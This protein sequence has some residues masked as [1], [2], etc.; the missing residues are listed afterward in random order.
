MKRF[1]LGFVIAIAATCSLQ[2]DPPRFLAPLP[3]KVQEKTV[4]ELLPIPPEATEEQKPLFEAAI[5]EARKQDVSVTPQAALL[6]RGLGHLQ[7]EEYEDAAPYLEETLRLDPSQQA[8][9]EGLGWAYIKTDQQTRAKALWE[10]FQRLMPDQALPYALLGQIAVMEREWPLADKHFSKS[11]SI[12]PDQFD[13]RYWYGQNLMRLGK[14]EEAEDIFREL[15]KREPDR[16]DIQM[17]LASLLI[18]RLEYM[19][20]V[21]IYRN[22]NDELPDNPRFLVEQALLELRVGELRRADELCLEALELDEA[23]LDA[24]SL[25]ADIAEIAGLHDITPLQDLIGETKNPISR[26]ALR[27]RLA[28][29]CIVENRNEPRQ[30]DPDMIL[31]LMHKAIEE[32]PANVDYRILYAQYLVMQ[33]HYTKAHGVATTVLEKFNG[34]NIAAKK[35]LLELAL[36]ELRHE[37]A[38][39]I[40]ADIYSGL[41]AHDPMGHYY[42]A[43]IFTQLGRYADA[44]QEIDLMEA[45]ASKGA[46]LSLVYTALTESDWTPA[47]SVRRL[48][49]HIMALQREGWVLI[50]PTN[51]PAILK[52]ET[53]DRRPTSVEDGDVPATARMV[54]YLM[55]CFTGKRKFGKKEPV[56]DDVP[57]PKKYFTIVF[58]GDLRSSLLLGN[59]VAEDFGVPFGIFVPTAPSKDYVPSRAGWDELRKYA[60]TGNWIIGSHL[61]ASFEKKP[62][63]K[64]GKDMRAPLPNRIWNT[65]R[66]RVESMSEW[67]RRI[68]QEFRDSRYTIRHEMGLNDSAVGLVSYPFSDLGQEGAC[69]LHSIRD[70]MAT[71]VAEAARSY[72]VGFVQTPSGYTVFGDNLLLCRTY[73]PN[74]TDEGSDLVR[75]AYNNH[76]L[77]IA[78]KMRAEIAMLM[79]R[80]NEANI[81]LTSLR[82]DGYPEDLCREIERAI[83][84]HFQNKSRRDRPPLVTEESYMDDSTNVIIA[85]E[86]HEGREEPLIRLDHPFIGPLVFHS[87]ANDQIETFGLGLRAGLDITRNTTLSFEY[88]DSKMEQTVRP[89]WNAVIVTNVPYAKSKYKFKMQTKALKGTITHRL[90]NGTVLSASIGKTSKKRLPSNSSLTDINLQDDLNSH[91]FTLEGDDDIITAALG[92]M[93]NPTD[94]LRL[95]FIY[96]HDYVPSAVKNVDYHG[97]TGNVKWKPEDAWTVEAQVRYRTYSDDNAFYNAYL[98][99]MWQT[100]PDGGIWA[101]LQL[102]TVSTSEP[103]DFYW[104][105]YWDQRVLG[106]LR[107]AQHR[108][109]YH[110]TFDLLCGIHQEESRPARRYEMEVTREKTVMID[111]VANTVEET[112]TDYYLMEPGGSGW[113]KIW[114]F[115]GAY[116]RNLTSML[117]INIEGQVMA[118]RDYIDHSVLLYLRLRF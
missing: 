12:D 29:R 61:H 19:E 46:V 34:N 65:N 89:R 1:R 108:E 25:R 22:V 27:I 66:N 32:D 107:Y 60:A 74:W 87:K 80:P 17:D 72:Q 26:A 6:Y 68:R 86:T 113:H 114:G 84:S 97:F 9:W 70:P 88:T 36:R 14:A 35:V 31:S 54:D 5:E 101:G 45:A 99:S 11:L 20:A 76:P 13:V 91:E 4:E 105:P 56:N 55:W 106:V 37:D 18:Q 111:G 73:A 118:L 117:T 109:G 85:S 103:T 49:E 83:H 39:Q 41:N 67:D 58:D 62:V 3:Q 71:L 38:L 94:N 102:A 33:N 16:L 59:E 40:V 116:G 10:Y 79:N 8:G 53:G 77:F 64:E 44:K 69:N 43:H 95:Q 93:W 24:M 51:I 48:H 23:N 57:K 42:R 78:R 21:E 75:H 90:E 115:G 81:M 98:E 47:T 112:A 15:I 28:N 7:D 82:R 30:Y 96:D 50:A 52:P 104:T 100:S 92:A 110:F 63:D 2:A